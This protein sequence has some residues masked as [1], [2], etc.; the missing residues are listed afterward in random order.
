MCTSQCEILK[1]EAC[2]FIRIVSFA[3]CAVVLIFVLNR[4]VH[5]LEYADIGIAR[6]D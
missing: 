2:E 1:T 3:R 4:K 5:Q 6:D